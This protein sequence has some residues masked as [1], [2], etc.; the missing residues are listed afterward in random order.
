MKLSE[1][2]AH[3]RSQPGYELAKRDAVLNR[4]RDPDQP[5]WVVYSQEDGSVKALNEATLSVVYQRNPAH[6]L[7]YKKT[8]GNRAIVA[9]VEANRPWL[10]DQNHVYCIKCWP[11][12][13]VRVRSYC[14]VKSADGDTIDGGPTVD[15]P[16]CLRHE[17]CPVCGHVEP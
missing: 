8:P 17:F 5:D 1:L 10:H 14:G 9:W 12:P 3:I 16:D 13:H 15:C 2:F 6:A 7:G 4:W 11:E